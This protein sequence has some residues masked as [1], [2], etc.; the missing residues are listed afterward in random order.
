M[1]KLFKIVLAAILF[2]MS[3][4]AGDLVYKYTSTVRTTAEVEWDPWQAGRAL[5]LLP[6]SWLLAVL[7]HELGH[8]QMG[9]W[10]GFRFQWLTVGPFK[11]KKE[12]GQLRFCWNTNLS[13]AGGMVLSVPIDDRN[14]RRRVMAFAAGGPVASL[15]WGVLVLYSFVLLPS[16]VRDQPFGL[17][18]G[19]SGFASLLIA[20]LTLVPMR[21]RGSA[22]DGARLLTLWRGGPASQLETTM[23]LVVGRSVGGVRPRELPLMELKAATELPDSLFNKV[24]LYYYLYLSAL[25]AGCIAQAGYYLSTYR[26]R[27]TQMPIALQSTIWLE[28]AF[29]AAAYE[30]DLPTARAFQAQAELSAYIPTDV[31]PRVAAAQ[32]RLTGDTTQARTLALNALRELPNNIDQGSSHFYAE[33]LNDTVQWSLEPTVGQH[34]KSQQQET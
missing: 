8:T 30:H 27:L 7:L 23:F 16:S 17:S 11:W 20:V 15:V 10:Q 34:G 22:N 6:L 19:L 5:V 31:L 28:S 26:Q 24:Y 4:W 21:F 32:A 9:R 29:F 13:M 1:K 14:L 18:L 12:S 25:D 2:T 3:L 33:W